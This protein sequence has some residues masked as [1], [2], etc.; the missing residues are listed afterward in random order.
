[1]LPGLRLA[2]KTGTTDDLRD[3]WFS[4]FDNNTLTTVWIGKD[5]YSPVGLTGS[6]GAMQ[7]FADI[8]KQ[9]GPVSRQDIQPDTV[10]WQNFL[11]TSGLLVKD[12]CAQARE[13]TGLERGR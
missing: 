10:S 6:Q 7:L 1:M 4:G 13:F 8:Y 11:P 5:D 12:D 9:I 2:G 3:S